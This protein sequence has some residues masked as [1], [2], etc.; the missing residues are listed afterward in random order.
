MGRRPAWYKGPK[1]RCDV[2]GW[3][4]YRDSGKIR[5]QRGLNVCPDCWDSL[6]DEQREEMI[7]RRKG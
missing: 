3:Y 6:T 4:E 1:I 5:K 2:C 7:Q